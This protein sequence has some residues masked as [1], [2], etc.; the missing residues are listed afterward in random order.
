MLVLT[1]K[2]GEEIVIDGDI[3]I[4]VVEVANGRVKLG[5][6]APK[7]VRVDRSEVREQREKADAPLPSAAARNRLAEV[8]NPATLQADPAV[9][10]P[11]PAPAPLPNRLPPAVRPAFKR[12]SR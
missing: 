4:T 5:I 12:K 6:A 2:I 11:T 1:R 10:V 9:I 3:R 7:H 8:V